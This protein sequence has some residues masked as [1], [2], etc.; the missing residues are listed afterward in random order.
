MKNLIRRGLRTLSFFAV[1]WVL[2]LVYSHVACKKVGGHEMSP[3]IEEGS[4]KITYPLDSPDGVAEEDILHYSLTHPDPRMTRSDFAARVKGLPG[5]T[6]K[7][8]CGLWMPEG[9]PL[10]EIDLVVPRDCFWLIGDYREKHIAN[11][12]DSRGVGP[13]G[14]WAVNGKVK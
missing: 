1:A 13:V 7:T 3:T 2:L 11:R 8:Q 12:V 4:F 14:F 6:V 10:E 9:T 5:Q